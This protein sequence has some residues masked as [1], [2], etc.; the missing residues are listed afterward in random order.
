MDLRGRELADEARERI[1]RSRALV[2]RLERR[3]KYLLFRTDRGTLIGHLGM[4]G[5][6]RVCR[7]GD[8]PRKHDH[9]DIVLDNGAIIARANA[10]NGGN[11]GI[12]AGALIPGLYGTIDASSR[13]GLDGQVVIDSPNQ[14]LTSI[15]VLDEPS[16]DI[17]ALIADPCALTLEDERSSLTVDGQ[18][19]LPPMP[20]DYQP[21]PAW[22][23]SSASPSAFVPA[24]INPQIAA[25]CGPMMP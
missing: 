9:V 20:D 12:R 14:H 8:P 22:N 17:T 4:S 10:G 3:A 1:Q 7:A 2:E 19:G 11:I 16:L 5:S 6:L 24:Q 25:A 15:T 23:G 18:G 13:A 21:A